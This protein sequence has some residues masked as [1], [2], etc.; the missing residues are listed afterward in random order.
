MIAPAALSLVKC[1]I[2]RC[3]DQLYAIDSACVTTSDA[4]GGA[5]L[6][7][8]DE[9][10]ADLGHLPFHYLSS[11]LGHDN[12]DANGGAVFVWQA[13]AYA[14]NQPQAQRYRISSD[15]VIGRQETLVRSLGRYAPRWAGVCGAAELFDGNV[16]L[17]LDLEELIKTAEVR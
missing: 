16:A 13:P 17:M 10:G 9:G 5:S 15:A 6:L 12:A 11:L 4:P 14:T 1:V 2:V 7:A 3:V 8:T